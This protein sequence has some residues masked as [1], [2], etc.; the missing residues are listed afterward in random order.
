MQEGPFARY[1]GKILRVQGTI[2]PHI[3][4]CRRYPWLRPNALSIANGTGAGSSVSKPILQEIRY[5]VQVELM[6]GPGNLGKTIQDAAQLQARFGRKVKVAIDLNGAN[7][8]SMARAMLALSRDNMLRLNQVTVRQGTGGAIR[9]ARVADGV[10]AGRYASIQ[11]L[12]E[13]MARFM[14]HDAD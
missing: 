11:A 14:A 1:L 12:E 9:G 7:G 5:P 6:A 4:I 2:Y 10:L 3:S 13:K 8:A